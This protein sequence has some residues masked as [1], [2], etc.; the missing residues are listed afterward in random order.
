[1]VQLFVFSP[2]NPLSTCCV[3]WERQRQIQNQFVITLMAILLRLF[4]FHVC[5]NKCGV[6]RRAVW[7]F[8][9]SAPTTDEWLFFSSVTPLS[10]LIWRESCQPQSV[11]R[12]HRLN[13]APIVSPHHLRFAHRLRA[14][15]IR[16]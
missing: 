7:D 13:P 11:R 1:W 5:P 14:H 15:H 10:I 8:A 6:F 16:L 2:V 3:L 12:T 4:R 9:L